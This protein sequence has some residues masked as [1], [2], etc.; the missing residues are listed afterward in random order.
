[1]SPASFQDQLFSLCTVHSTRRE[2]QKRTNEDHQNFPS[3]KGPCCTFTNAQHACK[4]LLANVCCA[5]VPTSL[6]SHALEKAC[7]DTN[8]LRLVI[9]CHPSL[10]QL[11]DAASALLMR[12]ME[13]NEGFT[14]LEKNG[15]IISE[16]RA[17]RRQKLRRWVER[18]IC[19]GGDRC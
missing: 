1:M 14:Y 11:G 8:T 13:T 10:L 4:W 9:E 3:G 18:R 16:M 12:F 19:I 17:W 6:H 5:S 7:D 15:Y 2:Q